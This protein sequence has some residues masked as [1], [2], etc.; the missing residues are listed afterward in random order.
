LG[1]LSTAGAVAGLG[2]G[3][4]EAGQQAQKV[5]MVKTMNDLQATRETTL[6]RLKE[7]EEDKRQAGQIQAQKDLQTSGQ[8]FEAGQ[9]Q[10]KIKSASAA[11]GATRE[12]EHQ[13]N[14]AKE[15]AAQKRTETSSN[16]RVAAASVRAPAGPPKIWD[17]KTLDSSYID[18][19][20]GPVKEQ[21]LLMFNHFTGRTYVPIGDKM[22]PWDSNANAPANDPK[23]LRRPGN[24]ELRDLLTDPLG[25]IPNGPNQGLT[26]ADAFEQSHGYL[27]SQWSAA[28]AQKASPTQHPQ[29]FSPPAAPPTSSN[30]SGASDNAAQSGEDASDNAPPFQS[31]AMGAYGNVAQ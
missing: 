6:E 22:V 14:V 27:P 2:A 16:A 24:D 29:L 31:N 4:T 30:D 5:D 15:A 26:K 18:P 23:A 28:A 20:K 8:T 9:T 13:E 19:K 11:A 10:T 17:T 3:I 1:I 25:S 12:F 21:K 7:A